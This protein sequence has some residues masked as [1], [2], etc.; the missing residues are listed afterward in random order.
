MQDKY[1]LSWDD[2]NACLVH[3]ATN[4]LYNCIQDVRE[5]SPAVVYECA[6]GGYREVCVTFAAEHS[7]IPRARE[8]AASRS[9][10][11]DS[12]GAQDSRRH[13]LLL[14]RHD[15]K[16]CG[17]SL[18]GLDS[19]RAA[20]KT[21]EELQTELMTL[22]EDALRQGTV[23]LTDHNRDLADSSTHMLGNALPCVHAS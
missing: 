15:L 20:R 6:P 22:V 9:L 1:P 3:S 16:A 12:E 7:V 11:G 13:R 4:G 17:W 23:M 5:R 8:Q 21:T 14:P 19:Q 10:T 18:H 2:E